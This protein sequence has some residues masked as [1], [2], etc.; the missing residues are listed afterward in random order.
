MAT[1]SGHGRNTEDIVNGNRV[2]APEKY[3]QNYLWPATIWAD[4]SRTGISSAAL[5]PDADQSRRDT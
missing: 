2:R 4:S 3:G 1:G 5:V